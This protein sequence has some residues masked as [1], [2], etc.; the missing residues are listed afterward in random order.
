MARSLK[1]GP[2][3]DD[4]LKKLRAKSH[5]QPVLLRHGHEPA[6]SHQKWLV[7]FLPF[8]MARTILKYWFQKKWSDTDLGEFSPTRKF[9]KHGGKMQKELE[10]KK[11]E[12]EIAAAQSAKAATTDAKKK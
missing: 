1:K 7:L 9:V 12:S 6:K 4:L 8:I 10:Q 11:K 5:R 3:V 2:Y